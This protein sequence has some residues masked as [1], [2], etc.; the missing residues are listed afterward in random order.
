MA[1]RL[2]SLSARHGGDYGTKDIQ[3][4]HYGIWPWGRILNGACISISNLPENIAWQTHTLEARAPLKSGAWGGRPTC[5]PQTRPL[6]WFT[7]RELFSKSS[8]Y[9][10]VSNSSCAIAVVTEKRD[11]FQRQ[12]S[13]PTTTFV[14]TRGK[15]KVGGLR[16]GS[17]V[18][19]QRQG[20]REGFVYQGRKMKKMR[21]M[22]RKYFP[23]ARDPKF[24]GHLYWQ[25]AE[26]SYFSI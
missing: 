23:V 25:F 10:T 20:E 4:L 7:Q 18:E 15:Q 26:N 1:W 16:G 21:G 22:R 9:S 5:H 19:R 6:V 8:T 12:N 2:A 17:T 14:V 24:E 3:V 13:S 11:R